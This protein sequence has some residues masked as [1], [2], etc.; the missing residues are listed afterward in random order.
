MLWPLAAST[1][2]ESMPWK[3]LLLDTL[4]VTSEPLLLMSLTL[5]LRVAP[6]TAEP[7]R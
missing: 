3:L 2:N 1:R 6:L 5:W 7:F 4:K